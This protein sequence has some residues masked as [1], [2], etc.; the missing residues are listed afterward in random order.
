MKCDPLRIFFFQ[1]SSILTLPQPWHFTTATT[2]IAVVAPTYCRNALQKSHFSRQF[3]P[4]PFLVIA[5]VP[6]LLKKKITFNN[7]PSLTFISK[8]DRK[9]AEIGWGTVQSRDVCVIHLAPWYKFNANKQHARHTYGNNVHVHCTVHTYMHNGHHKPIVWFSQLHTTTCMQHCTCTPIRVGAQT[10][11]HAHAI[12]TCT[13]FQPRMRWNN[14]LGPSRW[15]CA[16]KKNYREEVVVMQLACFA[17]LG[18]CVYPT[19]VAFLV[20]PLLQNAVSGKNQAKEIGST[21]CCSIKM[22]QIGHLF[23]ISFFM[24]VFLVYFFSCI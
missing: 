11:K 17:W 2:A 7:I 3:L 5:V 19:L 1:F 23:Q 16:K 14:S 15:D 4:C 24:S 10:V 21:K 6:F 8:N 20:L 9:W 22:L 13:S 12:N 18:W